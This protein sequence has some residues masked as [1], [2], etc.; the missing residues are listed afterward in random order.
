MEAAWPRP[1]P[2]VLREKEDEYLREA[3]KR[4]SVL[5]GYDIFCEP[6]YWSDETRTM[7][8]NAFGMRGAGKTNLLETVTEQDI[9]RG[10]PIIFIDG[11]GD[12]KLLA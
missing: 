8:S 3:R 5:L 7:Q 2:Y 4:S 12:K 9:L 11:K 1:V 10:V 6:F